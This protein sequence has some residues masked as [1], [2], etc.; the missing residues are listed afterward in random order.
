MQVLDA[1]AVCRACNAL[2]THLDALRTL[3]NVMILC[4]SN[5]PDAVDAA[6]LD[7]QAQH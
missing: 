6:F 5:L 7:R 1:V 2:L 3:P 4:T